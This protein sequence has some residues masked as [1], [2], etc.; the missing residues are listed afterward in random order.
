FGGLKI[1]PDQPFGWRSFLD[2]GDEPEAASGPRF[3]SAPEPARR[4]LR[5]RTSV[6]VAE[7]GGPLASGDLAALGL[8]D[9][10][11]LVGHAGPLALRNGRSREIWFARGPAA[12]GA[13][14][15]SAPRSSSRAAL[16]PAPYRS[17]PRPLRRPRASRRPHPPRS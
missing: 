7:A 3:E 13:G 8:A 12:G 1:W 15:I 17:P 4:R 6:E 14:L 5:G 2:F 16:S 10:G 11:E 9:L